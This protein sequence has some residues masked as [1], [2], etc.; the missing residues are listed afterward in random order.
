M[1]LIE[2]CHPGLIQ[3]TYHNPLDAGFPNGTLKGEIII[4]FNDIIGGKDNIGNGWKM[5]MECLSAGRAISLPATANASSKVSTYGIY[6][7]INIRDQFKMPLSKM[8]AI[9]EKFNNMVY[10]TWIIDSSID[11]TND[12]LDNGHSPSVI[13]AIMKQQ[14]TERGR[15]VLNEAMD[16]HGGAGICVGYNNFLEKY[17]KSAPIGINSRRE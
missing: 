2:S 7:Y 15:I 11:M 12:I 13:S 5:L 14:C 17:Y 16:I 9:Q 1:A 8:E 4:E 10:N 6:N 3:E